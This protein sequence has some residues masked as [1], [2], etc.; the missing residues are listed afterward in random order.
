MRKRKFVLFLWKHLKKRSYRGLYFFDE[1]NRI[2]ITVWPHRSSRV[3]EITECDEVCGGWAKEGG[4]FISDISNE[5]HYKANFRSSMNYH[6]RCGNIKRRTDPPFSGENFKNL[7]V[8]Q[9]AKEYNDTHDSR[10]LDHIFILTNFLIKHC[11][12]SISPLI[13]RW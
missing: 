9:F 3:L 1:R 10:T 8:Y 4:I 5:S 11:N 13:L 7:R 6:L 2:F 12:T